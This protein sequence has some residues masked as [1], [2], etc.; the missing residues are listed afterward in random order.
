M[1]EVAGFER[2]LSVVARG[3]EYPADIKDYV[4]V[5][6]AECEVVGWF[7]ADVAME[8][9]NIL[10][11]VVIEPD[12]KP[13]FDSPEGRAARARIL[14]AYMKHKCIIKEAEGDVCEQ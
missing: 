7:R 3:S 12:E 5:I 14:M 8:L 2:D 10:N 1:Y 9:V 11:N 13:Y 4:Q 6:D